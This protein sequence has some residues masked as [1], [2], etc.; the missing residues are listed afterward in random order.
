EEMGY[1]QVA[2]M[3]GL[4]GLGAG[5]G[6]VDPHPDYL[7]YTVLPTTVYDEQLQAIGPVPASMALGEHTAT[8]LAP[9]GRVW[10]GYPWQEFTRRAGLGA[11]P[12]TGNFMGVPTPLLV[13]GLV[14]AA[15]VAWANSGPPEPSSTAV[16]NGTAT[17]G[18]SS[19]SSGSTPAGNSSGGTSTTPA[20]T[21]KKRPAVVGKASP[22]L[23]VFVDSIGGEGIFDRLR[24]QFSL[25]HAVDGYG[26]SRIRTLDNHEFAGYA[27]GREWTAPDSGRTYTQLWQEIN[28]L[29]YNYWIEKSQTVAMHSV[30]LQAAQAQG[31]QWGNL[32]GKSVLPMS[33]TT[34]SAIVSFY[35]NNYLL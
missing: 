19:G 30:G 28:N 13:L 4:A 10:H 8:M 21:K 16:G 31:Y 32:T 20:T 18:N 25:A 1:F 2:L 23:Y 6:A 12:A 7:L 24:A 27:T 14:A 11:S 3:N 33:T 17:G 34:L 29:Q 5:L 26:I 15:G 35:F 9:D 22:A